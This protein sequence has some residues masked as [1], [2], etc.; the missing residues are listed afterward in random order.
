LQVQEEMLAML[1]IF[2]GL[3]PQ[4]L[5]QGEETCKI[6]N[7]SETLQNYKLHSNSAQQPLDSSQFTVSPAF[8][9]LF[10][11]SQN[12]LSI[13]ILPFKIFISLEFNL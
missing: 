2:Q 3:N 5:E 4:K 10:H 1:A 7:N 9:I 11:W 12:T 8:N 13:K 6:M